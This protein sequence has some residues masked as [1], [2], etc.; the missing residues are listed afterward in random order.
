MKMEKSILVLAVL[1]SAMFCYGCSK[2]KRTAVTE[3]KNPLSKT[4]SALPTITP[5]GAAGQKAAVSNIGDETAQAPTISLEHLPQPDTNYVDDE[6]YKNAVL[7]EGNL[8]RLAAAMRKAESGKEIT[9]GVIGGSITQGSLASTP[10][11]CYASRFFYW[12]KTAFVN[13]KVNIVNAGIGGTT[14]Y[15]GVH[16]VN[17]DLL[18][19]KPDVVIVEFSVNDVNTLFFKKT[20]EDLVR[21]LLKA[22]NNP[23]VILLFMPM[24]NGS[25][26]QTN[27]LLIGFRYDLPRISYGQLVFKA[28][29]KGTFTWADISPDGIHPNDRG[30]AMV[31]EVLFR[32]LD[33]VYAKLDTIKDEVKPLDTTPFFNEAY[34]DATILDSANTEPERMGSFQKSSV[35]AVF[36]ND[37]TTTSGNDGIVFETEARN[38]GIMY[39]KTTDGKSGQ[40]DVYIDDTF[41][42]TLDGDFTGGWGNY[43]ETT[44]VY[45]S[46]IR[47]KHKIEIK[48]HADSTGDVFSILGLLI[49]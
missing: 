45:S 24:E 10:D 21:R 20:Y 25:G 44:E 36:K 33:T 15:L 5:T 22:E 46:D 6:M 11:K 17:Q 14:S 12:W 29:E 34:I 9:V 47:K 8:A 35:D 39:R 2:Q 13:T 49:S 42:M 27:D 31:G 1:L 23:A 16:R 18:S 48:R 7:A 30:H 32:Y 4:P 28:V 41:T 43:Q 37:W 26:A 19:K 3:A 40:F 38:I